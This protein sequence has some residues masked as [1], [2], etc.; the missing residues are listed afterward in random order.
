[1]RRTCQGVLAASRTTTNPLGA[2]TRPRASHLFYGRVLAPITQCHNVR[3]YSKT[4]LALRGHAAQ[5]AKRLSEKG[6]A[7]GEGL[8]SDDK[9]SVK[10]E[11]KYDEVEYDGRLDEKLGEQAE[12]QSRTPWHREGAD[13]PPVKRM[14]SAGAMTKGIVIY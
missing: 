8:A 13:R 14:R 7:D 11:S 12:K 9:D 4:S 2:S 6:M 3:I 10:Q 5:E 1:M